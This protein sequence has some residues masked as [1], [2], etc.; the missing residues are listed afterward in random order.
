MSTDLKACAS[1]VSGNPGPVWFWFYYPQEKSGDRVVV[2]YKH[3]DS[4]YAPFNWQKVF[5]CNGWWRFGPWPLPGVMDFTQ[6]FFVNDVEIYQLK[7]PDMSQI[8]PALPQDETPPP[9]PPPVDPQSA[10]NES[11]AE[12]NRRMFECEALKDVT[13]IVDDGEEKAH[14]AVLA[15][16]SEVFESMFTSGMQETQTGQVELRSTSR[17]A[18]RVFLRLVYTGG[19]E[20]ADWND[21][22]AERMPLSTL[23]EA[24]GL[25]KKYMVASVLQQTLEALKKRVEE[26]G[27][28]SDVLAIEELIAIAVKLDSS[29]LRYHVLSSAKVCQPLQERYNARELKPEVQAELEGL[30]PVTQPIKK[31]RC[32]S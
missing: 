4:P 19:V 16:A 14:K 27:T 13:F 29:A 26:A 8:M 1:F 5:F 25:A 18:M 2:K 15:A 17:V 7:G 22:Q 11:V 30:W 28:K 3:K 20:P 31:R 23:G 21:P 12:L 24:A 10:V 32:L 6:H 9:P